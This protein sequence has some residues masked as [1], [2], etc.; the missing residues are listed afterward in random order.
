MRE[1]SAIEVRRLGPGMHAV[2]GVAGLC[3]KVAEPGARSWILR[4]MVGTKRRHIGLGS[5][6]E[7]GL[8]EARDRAREAKRTIEEGRDPVEE[9]RQARARL[10]E[11][12]SRMTFED[13]AAAYLRT[14]EHEFRSPKHRQQ[15]HNTLRDHA[16][17]VFGRVPVAD[18]ELRHVVDALE[19]IWTT[20]TETAKRLRGRIE[21]VLAWATVSGHREGDN[22]ARWRGHLDKV[23]PAPGKVASVTHMRA[24]PFDD[25]P[26]F[27]VELRKR[28]G[29]SARAL[30]FLVLTAARSGEVR[31]ATWDE[32]DLEARVWTI[33]ASR[34]KAGK[35]HRVPLSDGAVALLDGLGRHK[36]SP[37]VFTAPRGGMLSDMALTKVLRTMAVPATAHGFRSSFRDWSAERTAYPR[38]VCEMA[39]AHRIPDAVEAA[40]RRG[41]LFAK[42][43][44]LMDDWWRFCSSPPSEATVTPIREAKA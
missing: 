18:V 39:L 26:A 12:Q 44:R 25:V 14:K 23:L 36:G 1:L 33:P 22:P 40:Y 2:G 29:V 11:A 19:P 41:D 32:I 31:G 27:L 37:Y 10:V 38:E 3:L 15:W 28:A 43:T 13:A 42:R 20:R 16:Y 4:T 30:E 8:S 21:A 5:F 6:P 9:R 7:V 34:M 35:E 17:P 24:L